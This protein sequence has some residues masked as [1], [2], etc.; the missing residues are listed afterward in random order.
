MSDRADDINS[1]LIYQGKD[2]NYII[3]KESVFQATSKSSGGGFTRISG[4]NDYRIS[5]YDLATGKLATRLNMKE[6]GED[7]EFNILGATE[8]KLWIYS[9][10]KDMGLH[11]RNPKTLEVLAD[12]KKLSEGPLKGITVAKPE[13]SQIERYFGFDWGNATPLITDM[14]GYIYAIDANA[15]SANKL[16]KKIEVK[17]HSDNFTSSAKLG[18]KMEVRLE[19]D[20]R[21]TLSLGYKDE[22]KNAPSFLFGQLIVDNDEARIGQAK[23]Q[24]LDGLTARV[25]NLED[26]IKNYQEE[27]KDRADH[28]YYPDFN[29]PREEMDKYD[30]YQKQTWALSSAKSDLQS[31]SVFGEFDKL[32]L[33]NEPNTF[34]VYH[35]NMISDTSRAVISKVKINADN[36]ATEVWKCQLSGFYY[37]PDK[38]SHK[39]AFETVF[40]K[41]DPSFRYQW[42]D[43]ADNKLVFISQLQMGCID[44]NTGKLLWQI[45]I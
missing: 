1:S 19:G 20:N 14:Q 2:G 17:F 45:N 5:V 18:P 15:T 34:L 36:S 24:H 12:Q 30:I 3:N 27:H 29:S 8:G 44:M 25:K 33:S 41:G 42:F 32:L 22:L 6:G 16:D 40:S 23:K 7:G 35:A 9:M 38:A 31:A 13:W 26:S 11:Y 37:D 10:N 39:G 43:M 21:K 4:Y 28:G